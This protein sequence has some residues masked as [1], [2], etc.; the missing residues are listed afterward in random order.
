[1]LMENGYILAAILCSD[2]VVFSHQPSG[3]FGVLFASGG[4]FVVHRNH[5]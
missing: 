1:M 4:F 5:Y 3:V 2:V